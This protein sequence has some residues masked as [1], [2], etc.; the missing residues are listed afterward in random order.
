MADSEPASSNAPKGS[1]RSA[2]PVLGF[3]GV[4]AIGKVA[5]ALAAWLKLP[6][7]VSRRMGECMVA[8]LLVSDE[9]MKPGAVAKPR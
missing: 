9:S 5:A 8:V 7:A 1:K 2:P 4:L 6:G 3:G